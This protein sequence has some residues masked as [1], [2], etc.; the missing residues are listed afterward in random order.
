MSS[1]KKLEAL[2]HTRIIGIDLFLRCCRI[3]LYNMIET[4]G[5]LY[6]SYHN[7]IMSVVESCPNN[8]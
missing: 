8:L 5:K 1:E 4:E 7:N 2:M 6:L 3:K